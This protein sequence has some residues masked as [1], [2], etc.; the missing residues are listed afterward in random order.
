[1]KILQNLDSPFVGHKVMAHP[2][3]RI[4]VALFMVFLPYLIGSLIMELSN[5]LSEYIEFSDD[6]ELIIS[7]TLQIIGGIA[8]VVG[9]LAAY[10][11]YKTFFEGYSLPEL[12]LKKWKKELGI[13][14]LLGALL[15]LVCFVI[16]YFAGGF[17]VNGWRSPLII[18]SWMGL[19]ISAAFWEELAFRGIIFRITEDW[20]GSLA[21]L[22]ISALLFGFIHA[23]NPNATL[24]SSVA[25]SIEAGIL[26]G[27][28]YMLTQRLWLV[29]GIHFTWNFV[30]GSLL[31]IPVSGNEVKGIIKTE[32]VGNDLLTGGTFGLET[33]IVTLIFCTLVGLIVLKMAIKK[34][35]WKLPKA[36]RKEHVKEDEVNELE[37]Y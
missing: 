24:F 7:G 20:L 10:M 26:L 22:V 6:V 19:W 23:S 14:M 37:K 4:F 9:S 2:V 28:C 8:V 15:M 25:I 29:I 18:L 30:Q 21:A 1:M 13:G 3:V 33:S 31:D 16:I 12:S 27:A 5:E 11:L 32:E 36:M 35:R 17:T 34:G